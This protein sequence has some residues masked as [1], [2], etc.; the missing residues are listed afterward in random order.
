MAFGPATTDVQQTLLALL[1]GRNPSPLAPVA[2]P[3]VP[4]PQVSAPAPSGGFTPP[5]GFLPTPPAPPPEPAPVAPLPR[6][7]EN[8]IAQLT[9]AR[10]VAPVVEETPLILRIARALQ[11][12]GAGVQGQGPQFLAQLAEQREAPQREFRA[13]TERFEARRAGAI[14]FAERKRE[15]EQADIQ[16][17]ADIQ[18]DRE[19][20][21]WAQRAKITDETALLQ[22]RQA[23][24]L[25]KLREQERIADERLERQQKAL[26]D[27]QRRAFEFQLVRDDDAPSKIARE[28]ADYVFTGKPMSPAAEK[29]RSLRAQTAQARL[30]R[31]NGSGG[32]GSGTGRNEKAEKARQQFEAVKQQVIEREQVGDSAGAEQLRRKMI[33]MHSSLT[34]FGPTFELGYGDREGRW[35]YV[36]YRD[37]GAQSQGAPAAGRGRSTAEQMGI[38]PIRDQMNFDLSGAQSQEVQGPPSGRQAGA[39]PQRQGATKIITMDQIRAEAEAAGISVDEAVQQFKRAGYAIANMQ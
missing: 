32:G 25:N 6:L 7:D 13:A 39:T 12:F 24:D 36:K 14:E 28:I 37:Q 19:F 4:G 20:E 35:P 2:L 27:R 8:L 38:Q 18:S 3:P 26:D 23:F 31:L 21:Q 1:Q 11:G 10:P 9:G 29:W 30:G 22:A 33:S 17:R 15:R 16:R 34:R 5:G